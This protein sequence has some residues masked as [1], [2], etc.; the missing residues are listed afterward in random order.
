MCRVV[1]V[2]W[3]MLCLWP[4]SA[5]LATEYCVK[6]SSPATAVNHDVYVRGTPCQFLNDYLANQTHYFT[7]N[8][9]FR[10]LPGTHEMNRSLIVHNVDGL[11]LVRVNDSIDRSEI[12]VS[13]TSHTQGMTFI[14]T[15]NLKIEGMGLEMCGNVSQLIARSGLIILEGANLTLESLLLGQ[16]LP[17]ENIYSADILEQVNASLSHISTSRYHSNVLIHLYNVVNADIT[18]IKP[19]YD[20]AR[21][22]NTSCVQLVIDVYEVVIKNRE[23]F[24]HIDQCHLCQNDLN[25]FLLGNLKY[26]S[27]ETATVTMNITISNSMFEPTLS[28]SGQILSPLSFVGIHYNSKPKYGYRITIENSTF[29]GTGLFYQCLVPPSSV[30][31]TNV[32]VIRYVIQQDD[33]NPHLATTVAIIPCLDYFDTQ[34]IISAKYTFE[35]VVFGQ[36]MYVPVLNAISLLPAVLI[37]KS[38]VQF[39]NCNFT[40]NR[41]TALYVQDSNVLFEGNITFFNNTG[42]DGGAMVISG[43]SYVDRAP[44]Y[45]L[46][47]TVNFT[48]NHA[49]H[50]G[51]AILIISGKDVGFPECFLKSCNLHLHFH[52]NTAVQGGD[53]IYGGYLDQ[54]TNCKTPQSC[55]QWSDLTCFGEKAF[56]CIKMV[57]MISNFTNQSLSSVTSDPTRVCLCNTS[58]VPDCLNV[59]SGGIAV[60]P[61]QTFSLSAVVVGQTFGRTTGS[62]CPQLLDLNNTV[63][64]IAFMY[65]N[66]S[67]CQIVS[68]HSCQQLN[69][70]IYS[71]RKKEV[72]VF[73]TMKMNIYEYGNN[74]TIQQAIE[75]YIEIR[76]RLSVPR[77]LLSTPVYVN[78][79]LKQ[80]PTGFSLTPSPPY[81]CTCSQ[82]LKALTDEFIVFCDI[83]TQIV[84]RSGTVWIGALKNAT[85]GLMW[86]KYCPYLYCSADS[87]SNLSLS[88]LTPDPQCNFNHSGVLCGQCPKGMSLALG[89]SQCLLTCSDNY[90]SLIIAFAVAGVLLVL[91]IKVLNLT[92]TQGFINGLIFYA[93]IVKANETIF[94]PHPKKQNVLSIFISWLNLD[95]G[96]ETC[97]ID[98]LDGYTKTWLQFVFPFYLWALVGCMIFLARY[99]SR[100]TRLL[101]DSPV[102]IVATLFFLSYAKLFSTIIVA[103]DFVTLEL[104]HSKQRLVWAYD[105]SVDYLNWK[106]AI[107]FIVA[108]LVLVCLWLPYTVVLLFGQQ[109]Q[110]CKIDKISRRMAKLKPFLDA[111]YGP[112][113]DKHR[114]WFG[115]LLFTRAAIILACETISFETYKLWA[116]IAVVVLLLSFTFSIGGVYRKLYV[117]I[118][119]ASLFLNLA[120]ASV[121]IAS[122]DSREIRIITS[123]VLPGFVFAEF[124]AIVLFQFAQS[125][126]K[127]PCYCKST[128][129]GNREPA[130]INRDWYENLDFN[131]E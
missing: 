77:L 73:S 84:W 3:L 118:A 75:N 24:I 94:F 90:L 110:R 10:F 98:G 35:N 16:R 105:G 83:D 26:S 111:H 67:V 11:H 51:G 9:V 124:I 19:R 128:S 31:V 15:T 49:Y 38:T 74:Q 60:Y 99:S 114:Y 102:S 109:L 78:V 68:Q 127:W 14:N 37:V 126:K 12:N 93:N 70:Q 13:A 8:T 95:Q 17:C 104:P 87:E 30:L 29:H 32:S 101:G 7:N 27:N 48:G 34:E 64:S 23:Y 122:S 54:A 5:H 72:L 76:G 81:Q 131:R 97:F 39:S 91:F 22:E 61:G 44:N 88:N 66:S 33:N 1:L 130:N 36:N 85:D 56:S 47:T 46:N 62:V 69:L 28:Q 65:S 100:M 18:H 123:Y 129:V 106:H 80:C 103:L 115:V 53:D 92:V 58:G 119:E 20:R 6:P 57:H 107:L 79:T 108:L 45:Q 120:I 113:K 21:L 112:F 71:N 125:I 41:G 59:L 86:T 55:T 82:Q 2:L 63:N 89:S 50:T 117:T 43:Q 52:N 42:Y 116:I 40:S 96:I 25:S 4:Q 121:L